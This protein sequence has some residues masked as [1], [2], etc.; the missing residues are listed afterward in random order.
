M[1]LVLGVMPA[2][3]QADEAPVMQSV[4]PTQG[5]VGT[6]VYVRGAHFGE[7]LSQNSKLYFN[8]VAV[9]YPKIINW[10]DTLIT[11]TVPDGATTGPVVVTTANGSSNA[12]VTFT[13]T[14]TPEISA[15]YPSTGPVGTT[16]L[17]TGTSFGTDGVVTFNNVV[18]TTG[19]WSGT[20]IVTTVPEG[21]TTGPV[22]VTTSA[23]A[24]NGVT[25]TVTAGPAQTWYLAEGSTAHGFDTYV[26]M[27]NP[28]AA[29]ATVNVIYN[30]SRGRIP[31]TLPITV[32]ASSRVTLH[33][34]ED[35]PNVDVSTTLQS[36][37][38]IVAERAVYWN[39]RIEGTD[40]IGVT[41][42]SKTWYLAEGSTA[43]GFETWVLIQNPGTA[44]A[45][46][47]VTYMTSK[48]IVKKPTFP[49]AAGQRYTID[50]GKDVGFC[51]VSTKVESDQD[52]VC[53]RSMY[54]DSRRGGHDSIGVTSPSKTWY[55]AEGSTAWGFTTY[56]LI[57]NPS[58]DK[59]ATV[60]VTYMTK[61]GPAHEP[62]FTMGPGSRKTI[63]VNDSIADEDTSIMVD[64]DNE[65]I[66]ERAMYWDN[67]TGKAG[68]DTVGVPAPAT[69]IYLGE[70]STAWGFETFLCIQNPSSQD[71][72]VSVTY[73]TPNGP[74]NTPNRVVG[75][76][77]RLTVDVSQECPNVDASIKVQSATP[78]MAERAM[79]WHDRGGGHVSIGWNQ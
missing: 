48:G 13:V 79:Y 18:A 11:A 64:S 9:P 58:E 22:V 75:A 52:I 71:A 74:V 17:I 35:V 59:S 7:S 66:A 63:R 29:A 53:E 3:V 39:D 25:F 27:A 24:S 70:G 65:V 50:V 49:V 12:D 1:L 57:Q 31:R 33:V 77:S 51:D 73:M 8:G 78:I 54:W 34:T 5:P 36:N 43:F 40:S 15:I 47:D 14:D 60:N 55:L 76:N 6:T 20:A 46:V 69:N 41:A 23:G 42:A 67:G 21:A 61:F 26:L 19:T 45:N 44:A 30:T 68:H 56:L 10:T 28:N 32:P 37:V 72:V 16:V 4:T 2:A 62:T 38:P